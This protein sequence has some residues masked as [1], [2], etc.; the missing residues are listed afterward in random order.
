MYWFQLFH[1]LCI[2]DP[3]Y[4]IWA[5]LFPFEPFQFSLNFFDEDHFV[6]VWSL[7]TLFGPI[8]SNLIWFESLRS[9]SNNWNL[10]FNQYLP[11]WANLNQVEIFGTILWLYRPSNIIFSAPARSFYK[12]KCRSVCRSVGLSVEN[13]QNQKI[14]ILWLFLI[15]WLISGIAGVMEWR[16]R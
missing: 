12:S 5:I 6:V 1:L 11:F 4:S 3:F 13:F 10:F 9:H 14:K 8:R 15:I 2:I 7:F 16:L